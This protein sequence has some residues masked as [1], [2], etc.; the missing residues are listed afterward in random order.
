MPQKRT[1]KSFSAGTKTALVTGSVALGAVITGAVYRRLRRTKLISIEDIPPA[2]DATILEMEM[3]EGTVRYYHRAGTG[4]PIVFLHGIDA[5]GSSIDILPLFE[6]FALSTG[7][8]LYALEWLGYGLSDRPPVRYSSGLY[9]RHLRRFLSEI[10]LQPADIIAQG[11]AGE[12]ASITTQTLPFLV[13][14]LVLIAPPS[15][16][17]KPSRRVFRRTLGKT[18]DSLGAFEIYFHR[19][20]RHEAI[21]RF[22]A[23]HVFLKAGIV[24]D[25]LLAYVHTL[26]HT[27]GAHFAPRYFFD[28]SLYSPQQAYRSYTHTPTPALLVAP[29]ST[30]RFARSFD[31]TEDLENKTGGLLNTK[32]LSSGLMPQWESTTSI[33]TLVEEF[34]E[35]G[36]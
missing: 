21:R 31:G 17:S 2:L 10:V 14:K 29:E 25:T 30:T 11:L 34:L 19:I 1:R 5:F 4:T 26:A 7:Q 12:I 6:Y 27:H 16:S 13:N 36:R 35:E 32:K 9:Q 24:P 3:M 23:R 22:F 18:A 20:A 33:T 15:T 28:G 8:P